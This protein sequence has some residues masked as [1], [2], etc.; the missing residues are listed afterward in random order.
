MLIG[1]YLIPLKPGEAVPPIRA[2]GIR[3]E[4][5]FAAIPGAHPTDAV[6]LGPSAD[7]YAF[8]KRT[9]QRNLYRIPIS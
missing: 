4:D 7:V 2:G 3:S 5:D 6:V 1:G 8:Y 9:V